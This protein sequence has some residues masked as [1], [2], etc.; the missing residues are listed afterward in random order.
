M[1]QKR[2]IIENSLSNNKWLFPLERWVSVK[3][4][5][6]CHMTIWGNDS[7]PLLTL[8]FQKLRCYLLPLNSKARA[9][10]ILLSIIMKWD[11]FYFCTPSIYC[12]LIEQFVH[13]FIY[14]D[15]FLYSFRM[16][17][18]GPGDRGSNPV[19]VIP[20]TQKMVAKKKTQIKQHV[21]TPNK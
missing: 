18:N 7:H 1:L 10:A 8:F 11:F 9:I 2:Y 13:I 3:C 5:I 17:A 20:M 12:L 6:E 19:Q 21:T 14:C 15:T 4:L 16:F